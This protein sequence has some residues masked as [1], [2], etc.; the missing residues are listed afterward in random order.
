MYEEGLIHLSG[1]P[2]L[3]QY[4]AEQIAQEQRRGVLVLD[5]RPAEQFASFHIPGSMQLGLMGPFASWAALLI[6][7]TQELLLVAESATAAEEARSRL[8]RVG[9]KHVLGFVLADKKHWQNHGLTLVSLP[10][11]RSNDVS[12]HLREG[13]PLQLVDVRSSAEWLQGHL[14]G[15]TSVPLL[16]LHSEAASIDFS[17]PSLVYCHEGYRAST[18]ASMLLRD[19]ASDVGILIDGIEGWQACGLP[20]EMPSSPRSEYSDTTLSPV[21]HTA[22]E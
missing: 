7:S 13:R 3:Q 21:S 14:P 9:L 20:L 8:A 22:H 15:A 5:T 2:N 10:I 11:H 18:A 12:R 1:S 17:R 4:T 16:E 19:Y 6:E